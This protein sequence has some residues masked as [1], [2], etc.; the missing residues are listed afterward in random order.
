[1]NDQTLLCLAGGGL[2]IWWIASGSG[3]ASRVESNLDV[4]EEI[5]TELDIADLK[6]DS[7]IA[8]HMNA[9]LVNTDELR[10]MSGTEFSQITKAKLKDIVTVTLCGKDHTLDHLARLSDI[11]LRFAQDDQI[12]TDESLEMTNHLF[13]ISMA[14]LHTATEAIER[15]VKIISDIY[16]HL[17]DE[18]ADSAEVLLYN[19]RKRIQNIKEL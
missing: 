15:T 19:A 7:R 10:N 2:L 5:Y 17:P 1:M 3:A 9:I 6:K 12:G 16:Q 18:S 14:F 4:L 8:Y 13:E 11:L